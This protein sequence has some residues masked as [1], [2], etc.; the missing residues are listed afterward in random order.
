MK[1]HDYVLWAEEVINNYVIKGIIKENVIYLRNELFL[2][3]NPCF[4]SLH[5][6]GNL[7]GCIGSLFPAE[8][9]LYYEIRK[10]AVF[11]VSK[12]YRF[13][14]VEKE[15]IRDITVNVDILFD[16]KENI[17]SSDLDIKKYG[18][19]VKNNNKRGVLLPNIEGVETVSEQIRIALRKAGISEGEK[20]TIDSFR[21][22]RYF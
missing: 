22:E 4:V 21:V 2:R 6:N 1:K 10:N 9:S 14:P 7:R 13:L 3:K 15:E 17:S 8:Q 18:I 5:K 11:S 20:Y 16:L 12:D 19:I